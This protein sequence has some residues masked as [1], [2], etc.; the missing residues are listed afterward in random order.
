M[1][2]AAW[3]E[4]GCNCFADCKGGMKSHENC[5][6]FIARTRGPI[7]FAPCP[8]DTSIKTYQDNKSICLHCESEAQRK[9]VQNEQRLP[10]NFMVGVVKSSS[11]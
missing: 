7:V 10:A 4:K 1:S 6:Y 11:D 8:V 2:N 5:V 9:G 3:L